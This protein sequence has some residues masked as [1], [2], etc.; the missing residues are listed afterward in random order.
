MLALK[1][2]FTVLPRA[3]AADYFKRCAQQ[4]QRIYFSF[5][6]ANHILQ[7]KQLVF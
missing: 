6:K 5:E 3:F 1:I 7:R 4:E 2:P